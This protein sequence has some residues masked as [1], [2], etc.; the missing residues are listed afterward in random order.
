[1]KKNLSKPFSI[2]LPGSM[3]AWLTRQTEKQKLNRNQLI[4]K[5][6]ERYK[7]RIKK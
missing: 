2:R 5:A 6:V 4:I 3:L 7:R 1:M